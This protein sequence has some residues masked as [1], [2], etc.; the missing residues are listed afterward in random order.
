MLIV[1]T[2]RQPKARTTAQ[3]LDDILR[4]ET[5]EM[6]DVAAAYITGSGLRELMTV[7]KNSLGNERPSM[8]QR[9][10]TSFDYCRTEPIALEAILSFQNS[11]VR[12]FDA[13]FCI[14]RNC[15][16]RIPFHPKTFLLRSPQYDYVLSGSGNISR[17][18]LSHGYEAG[19][20]MG[21]DR[22]ADNIEPS[23]VNSINQS[24]SWF[25]SIW[26]D[27]DPLTDGLLAR[28]TNIFESIENRKT[29]AS[30]EDDTASDHPIKGALNS[31]DLQ[32]LRVCRNFWIE[33][34]NV[35]KNRGPNLPGNQIMMK[36]LT[37]VY[38]GFP[39]AA[40]PENSSIGTVELSFNGSPYDTYS[41]TYSDNKMDKLVLPIPG[42]S[43]PGEYDKK[44]LLF[45]NISPG[46]FDFVIGSE[47]D[48]KEW[49]KKSKKIDGAFTMKG[50]RKWGVY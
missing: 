3:A 24:R 46:R 11:S 30:T 43:G 8:E 18:G 36:R 37:R 17:S 16:P 33:A 7:F 4:H 35:T 12:V 50:G 40:V 32:K 6:M 14:S 39:P 1:D 38:F 28:Y 2:I 9:W 44:N 22:H 42:Q 15:T 48:K 13:E 10:L 5:P 31:A 41:I 34:G 45:R 26:D 49:L 29:P 23:V 47:A 25:L 21:F 19:I 27:S 20:S